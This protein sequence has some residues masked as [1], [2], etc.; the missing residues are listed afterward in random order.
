MC[1]SVVSVHKIHIR[2]HTHVGASAGV[3]EDRG[4]LPETPRRRDGL[5]ATKRPWVFANT[6]PCTIDFSS[7]TEKQ[8][9]PDDDL[10]QL[11]VTGYLV[12]SAFS[13]RNNAS[14]T[15]K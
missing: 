13:W 3:L 9:A 8:K 5:H 4:F 6:I 12:E 7:R 2:T 14:G 10:K 15:F 1:W 11:G